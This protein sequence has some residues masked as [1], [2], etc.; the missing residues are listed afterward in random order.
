MEDLQTESAQPRQVIAC[1]NKEEVQRLIEHHCDQTITQFSQVRHQK[2][3]GKGMSVLQ[4]RVVIFH[5]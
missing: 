4:L 2:N 5:V 3:F 1:A